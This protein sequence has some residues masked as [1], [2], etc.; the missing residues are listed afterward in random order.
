MQ[1]IL[2][3]LHK[4]CST[5]FLSCSWPRTRGHNM[6]SR[7]RLSLRFGHL[8][9]R[10]DFSQFHMT[11]SLMGGGIT[12]EELQALAT[13]RQRSRDGS[14]GCYSDYFCYLFGG[15]TSLI[16]SCS[17]VLIVQRSISHLS[18][19]PNRHASRC[20]RNLSG[21]STP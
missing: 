4:V 21:N 1:S 8:S 10:R 16:L 18:N 12:E 20:P 14:N 11:G 2:H 13:P 15:F 5:T 6:L 3:P 7:R 9:L 17:H 19:S